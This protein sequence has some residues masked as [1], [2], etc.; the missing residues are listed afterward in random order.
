MGKNIT[1]ANATLVMTVEELYPSGFQLEQFSTDLMLSQSDDTLAETRMGVDGQ[2]VAGF[3]PTILSTTIT[4]ES[5]SPSMEQLNTLY[6]A[7]KT[8]QRVYEIT[9][10]VDIPSLGKSFTYNGGVLKT[11]RLVPDIKKVLEP[12]SYGFDFEKVSE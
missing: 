6:K 1:S 4:L 5:S 10:V 2:M 11:G 3:V 8:N 12:V 7:M 9:L